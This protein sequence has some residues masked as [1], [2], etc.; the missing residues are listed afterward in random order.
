MMEP[1]AMSHFPLKSDQQGLEF[2]NPGERSLTHEAMLVHLSVEVTVPATFDHFSVPFIFWNVGCHTTIP[3]HLTHS[4]GI[5]TAICI[6][7]RTFDIQATAPHI[8]EHVR[9]LLLKVI[10]IIMISCNNAGR[11]NDRSIPIGYWQY[12]AC[13]CPLPALIG[14]FFTPFFAA[15]WLPS[16]LSSDKFKSPLML[17][18]LASKRRWRLPSLLHFRK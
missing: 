13:F 16:R 9:Y 1:K 4:A 7:N 11:R 2:V 8:I 3:Q 10:A 6:E 5:K 14:N 15:L 12:V 17:M 18:M